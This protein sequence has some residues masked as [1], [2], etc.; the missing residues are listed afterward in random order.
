MAYF[1]QGFWAVLLFQDVSS[2]RFKVA[3]INGVNIWLVETGNTYCTSVGFV[4][5]AQSSHPAVSKE[6]D[7]VEAVPSKTAEETRP[8]ATRSTLETP[9]HKKRKGKNRN[10][11]NYI[12]EK[13]F[14]QVCKEFPIAEELDNCV[15]S[16]GVSCL[17]YL[18][19]S[20]WMQFIAVFFHKPSMLW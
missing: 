7:K 10:T 2:F 19:T 1:R 3:C 4:I 11:W 20:S 17:S 9:E 16:A 18:F 6:D 13:Q 5:V 15:T 12:E 14:L 8:K